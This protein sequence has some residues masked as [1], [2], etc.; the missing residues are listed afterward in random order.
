[1]RE[2][3]H[4]CIGVIIM[5]CG[6][7]KNRHPTDTRS[8]I[9]Y[10]FIGTYSFPLQLAGFLWHPMPHMRIP[11]GLCPALSRPA[12]CKPEDVSPP[13]PLPPSH[14]FFPYTP[15][16]PLAYAS[17]VSQNLRP[18][19]TGNHRRQLLDHDLFVDVS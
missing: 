10:D 17:Q 19:G 8:L 11:E 15:D 9:A 4:S 3:Q 12:A 13:D 6:L 2:C 18:R 7:Q 16:T 14:H 1:M 5:H